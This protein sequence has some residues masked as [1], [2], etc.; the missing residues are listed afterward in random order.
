MRVT[1]WQVEGYIARINENHDDNLCLYGDHQGW[2]IN[3]DG[4]ATRVTDY[5][6]LQQIMSMLGAYVEGL[7]RAT[8][9]PA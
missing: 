9:W 7:R 3:R 2:C 4:G 8:L 6:T 5:G 1:R